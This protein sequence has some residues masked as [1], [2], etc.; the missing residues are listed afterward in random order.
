M[1]EDEKRLE[2]K[3]DELLRGNEEI[4]EALPLIHA[5]GRILVPRQTVNERAGLNKNTLA[6][7][8]KV[9]KYEPIGVRKTLIEI[10]DL[11]VVKKRK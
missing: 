10:S 11:T 6:Q 9:K 5:L 1:T 7:N 4:L 3:L 8:T 2:A